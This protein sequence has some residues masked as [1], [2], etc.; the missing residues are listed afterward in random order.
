MGGPMEKTVEEKEQALIHELETLSRGILAF[1]GGVDSTYLLYK[2]HQVMGK[3]LLAVTMRLASMPEAE[4]EDA[5]KLAVSIGT[6][7]E[8]ISMNQFD[9]DG[10]AENPENRCYLC[11]HFLFSRLKEK[12]AAEGYDCVMDGTNWDDTAVFR[13]GRKALSELGIQSPLRAVGL[14]KRDIRRLSKKARLP[15]WSKPSFPCMATRFPYHERITREKLTRVEAAENVLRQEGFTQFRV[16]SHGDL[17]RI[18]V[19]GE[20]MQ[21]LFDKKERL[22]ASLTAL[23]FLYV[24]MDLFGFAS[25]SMDKPLERK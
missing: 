3:R 25:G 6:R 16:R 1:S 14:T 11:K 22:C 2:A 19:P 24:T 10:F 18:E 20:D 7:H 17:A 13:P 23:G 21:A 12:A 9:I 15:T 5:K 4:L 8:V